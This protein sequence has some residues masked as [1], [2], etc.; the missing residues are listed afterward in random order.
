VLELQSG[1]DASG[2]TFDRRF[3]S[4]FTNPV[5]IEVRA[6]SHEGETGHSALGM[7]MGVKS[8]AVN[9]T[10]IVCGPTGVKEKQRIFG[11]KMIGESMPGIAELQF[12]VASAEG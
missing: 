7:D 12:M 3:F 10:T 1:E 11:S 4:P 8:S 2:K 9:P 6:G 5:F